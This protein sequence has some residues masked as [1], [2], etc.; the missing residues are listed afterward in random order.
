VPAIATTLRLPWAWPNAFADGCTGCGD[1]V[2]ACPEG[3]VALDGTR[4]AFVD[5]QRGG[6]LC[7]FCGACADICS[8]PIFLAP[9]LRAV[10][11]PWT[12]H[13]AIG[14]GCLTREGVM[15]QTCKDACADGVI[16]FAY[17]AGRVAQPVVDLDRCTGCGACVAPCPASAIVISR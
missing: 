14:D 4:H 7:S 3:I 10:T 12:L 11:P 15:C 16:R 2:T 1:C 8:E 6:G 13:I 9:E 5:F 17:T